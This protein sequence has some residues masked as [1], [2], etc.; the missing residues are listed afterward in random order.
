METAQQ[1]AGELA[2]NLNPTPITDRQK[3]SYHE[4]QGR[5]LIDKLVLAVVGFLALTIIALSFHNTAA[6]AKVLKLN[7]KLAACLV[8]M[9]FGTLLFIRARQRALQRNVPYFLEIGYFTSLAFVTA[10]NM[11][12]L[13][14]IHT[15]GYVV[16]AAITGAMWLMESTLVW[17]W[18]DSHRPHEK[19]ERE[20]QK[21]A[22][23][24]I[25]RTRIL[26]R[27]EWLRWESQKPDLA[28]IKEARK[29]ERKRRKVVENGLPDFFQTLNVERQTPDK[30]L[31][32][33]NSKQTAQSK[34]DEFH[35][36]PNTE[37]QTDIKHRTPNIEQQQTDKQ[38][39]SEQTAQTKQTNK[40]SSKQTEPAEQ[41]NNKQVPDKHQTD[42]DE[43]NIK[44]VR[45]DE[46]TDNQTNNAQKDTEQTSNEQTNKVIYINK[47]TV[48]RT[49]T[50]N[51]KG[52]QIDNEQQAERTDKQQTTKQVQRKRASKQTANLPPYEQLLVMIDQTFTA[53]KKLPTVRAFAEQ[54]NIKPN[55]AHTALKMWKEA[56]GQ[57]VDKTQTAN[58]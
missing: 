2:T 21:E 57:T 11:W 9:L 54:A 16:G 58:N 26:Q 27:I 7:P 17:L 51:K 15:T 55:R 23:K 56:N 18:T 50:S 5:S 30:K 10:V 25:K 24:E 29:A 40:Q 36:T 28:L 22:E 49:N 12:G 19:S 8:E 32:R 20:L 45:I 33:T 6:L 37:R 53:N 43:A 3:L 35:Q 42:K 41:T 47:Q 44:Q 1:P 48:E 52:K 14:Q 39:L 34:H 38:D 13:G 4:K 46:Q 31:E